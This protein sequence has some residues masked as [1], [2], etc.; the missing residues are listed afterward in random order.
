MFYGWVAKLNPFAAQ[1]G[2]VEQTWDTVAEKVADST[3]HLTKKQGKIELSG[4]ALR[5]FLA[6]QMGMDSKFCSWKTKLQEEST[7]SGQ[8]G[9][10]SNHDTVEYQLLDQLAAMKQQTAEESAALSEG[11]AL[12]KSIKD[13]QLND[14]I[15]KKCMKSEPAKKELFRVLN[16]KRKVLEIKIDALAKARKESRQEVLSYLDPEERLTLEKHEELKAE[17][18]LSNQ[19]TTDNYDSDE[20]ANRGIGKK[21]RFHETNAAVQQL[22]SK[23]AEQPSET[24]LERALTQWLTHKMQMQMQTRSEG[25]SVQE[26]LTSLESMKERRLVKED[27]YTTQRKRILDSL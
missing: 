1:R 6:K 13:D 16:K 9:M 19:T 25:A 2:Q 12:L 18:R 24:A 20:N 17:R 7:K 26:R 27:E 3:K 11:K 23:V 8:A 4:H 21:A 14:E 5:V 22:M 10:L 15:F